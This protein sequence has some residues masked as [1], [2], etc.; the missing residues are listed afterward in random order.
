MPAIDLLENLKDCPI[1]F[2]GAMGTR[3]YESGYFI[4]HAFDEANLSKPD[5]VRA[6][7]RE[8][9]AAGAQILQANTFSANRFLLS[10]YGAEESTIDIN[11]AGIRLAR[12]SA[13]DDIIVAGGG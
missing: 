7:H 4:N 12:E 13:N 6:C 2:D 8:Y 5:L 3:L 1:V 9:V 10:R 11:R